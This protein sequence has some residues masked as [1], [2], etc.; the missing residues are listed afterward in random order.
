MTLE[1]RKEIRMSIKS[2]ESLRTEKY[3]LPSTIEGILSLVRE[4]LSLGR[5]RRVELDVDL[6]VKV[7]R[8]VDETDLVEPNIDIDSALH[9]VEMVEVSSSKTSIE[10]ALK[11]CKQLYRRNLRPT[12][13]I[14]GPGTVIE[15]WAPVAEVEFCAGQSFFLNIP[16][17]TLKSL[18]SDSLILCGSSYRDA[19]VGDIQFAVKT[20]MEVR[21]DYE[22]ESSSSFDD[23]VWGSPT[24]R[25]SA[26]S[27]L[28]ISTDKL[29]RVDGKDPN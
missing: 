19:D 29:R 14:T 28:E 10:T 24:E 13:W 20:S 21:R 8:E 22:S 27:G 18:P 26:V 9:K 2:K 11:M 16:M 17:M 12:F 4:I 25:N 1:S 23:P 7:V 5:V 3:P 15:T 6:P